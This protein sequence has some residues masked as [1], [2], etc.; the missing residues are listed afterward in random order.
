VASDPDAKALART[1]YRGP[2]VTAQRLAIARAADSRVDR[3]F[4]I[5]ELA[6]D[7][8]AAEPRIGLATVYR[9]VAAMEATGFV[10]KL[11][12]RDGAALYAR[13]AHRGHHHHLMCTG[14]G[15]VT[16]VECTVDTRSASGHG[17][18]QITDHRLVLYGICG[19]CAKGD[20]RD[21][22]RVE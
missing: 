22:A 21:A 1:A 3:A 13:C 6:A 9:A 4:S 16:D 19:S 12:M 10:E 8:R 5:D 2:R 11:G 20:G 17:D 14:C 18:F 7:V 15:A